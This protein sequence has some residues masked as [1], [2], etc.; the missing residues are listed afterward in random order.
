[1]KIYLDES[2]QT[3]RDLFQATQPLL[4]Y[5]GVWLDERSEA[6]VMAELNH[7]RQRHAH[8]RSTAKGKDLIATRKGQAFLVDC[9]Y[10][11]STSNLPTSIVVFNKPYQAA[12]VIVEDCTDYVYNDQFEAAW[13]SDAES[14]QFLAEAIHKHSDARHLMA[15]WKARLSEPFD[16][17]IAA[18]QRVMFALT[19]NVDERLSNLAKRMTNANFRE[20]WEAAKLN[21]SGDWSYSPNLNGFVAAIQMAHQQAKTRSIP[22]VDLVHDRQDQFEQELTEVFGALTKASRGVVTV[23]SGSA[24]FPLSR[25]RSLTFLSSSLSEGVRLADLAANVVKA[26]VSGRHLSGDRLRHVV[27]W[28][29]SGGDGIFFIGPPTWQQECLRRVLETSA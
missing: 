13:I 27:R 26:I 28:L 6:A 14:K 29:R 20:I 19:L 12:A 23:S 21:Q 24:E 11:L 10:A 9:L 17:F 3:G 4:V 15:A 18:Y 16:V 7:V 1:M 25:F 5:A 22:T 8:F 2:G